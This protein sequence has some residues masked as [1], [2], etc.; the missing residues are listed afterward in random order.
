MLTIRNPTHDDPD[1]AAALVLAALAFILADER[2]AR[3]LLDLTGLTPDGLRAGIE[4]VQT[5]Q[6]IIAF[7]AAHEPDLLA[8][9]E[10]LGVEPET[11]LRAGGGVPRS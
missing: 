2:R 1:Q 9:A 6:A 7:L 5:H 10:A 4:D 3:R 11:L 8:A